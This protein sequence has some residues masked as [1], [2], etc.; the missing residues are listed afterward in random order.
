MPQVPMSDFTSQI[1]ARGIPYSTL[2]VAAAMAAPL[3]LIGQLFIP[4]L[5][6]APMTLFVLWYGL[7][8]LADWL[9]EQIP[10]Q[11]FANLLTW[12]IQGG[13]MYA[14]NDSDPVPVVMYDHDT[15]GDTEYKRLR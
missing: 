1:S 14:T 6:L 12:L 4:I 13:S 9:T 3:I 2:G 7:I 15:P 10:P 8:P 11:F 5:V